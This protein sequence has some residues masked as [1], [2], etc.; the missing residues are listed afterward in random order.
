MTDIQSTMYTL[1]QLARQIWPNG[2][3]PLGL[4]HKVLATPATGFALMIKTPAAKR[5]ARE[6]TPDYEALIAKL[7]ADLS[8]PP[9]GVTVEQQGPFWTGWYHYL[10]GI[11]RAS[12]W[13]PQ[14]LERAGKLLY[15]DRWQSDLA[16][17]LDV[18]DRRVREWAAGDRRPSAGIWADIAALLRQRQQ[19]G[20]ALLQELD[21]GTTAPATD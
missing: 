19:E 4:Q 14:Q 5:L 13:G 7:P 17:A 11:D 9:G 10:A 2:D 21:A 1:G 8:D 20:L 6:R 12:K 15:G 3:M 16:R 18:G